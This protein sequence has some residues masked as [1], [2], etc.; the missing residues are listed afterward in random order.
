MAALLGLSLLALFGFV[1]FVFSIGTATV[2]VNVDAAVYDKQTRAPVSNCLLAFEKS[3]TSGYG[4]TSARTD[5][6]GRSS[7]QTSH[8]YVGSMLWPFSRDRNPKLRFYVGEPSGSGAS[9]GV[10]AWDVQLHFREPWTSRAV[11]PRVA[12]RRSGAAP[13]PAAD[14]PRLAEAV[15]HFESNDRGGDQYRIPLS[16]FLDPE[17]SAA[18]RAEPPAEAERRANTLFNARK[19][20]EALTEYRE[21]AQ[22]RPE[23]AWAHQGIGDC[24]SHLDRGKEAIASY[25]TA[26]G[27]APADADIQFDYG[28]SLRDG[29]HE[30]A[31]A[32]F[33]RVTA[34]EPDK[35]RGFIGLGAS[36]YA[37]DRCREAVVAYGKAVELCTSCL[38]D[39]D[40]REYAECRQELGR[41]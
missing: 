37:L 27:L 20:Q 9:P 10:E 38:D 4:Q 25:R 11:V 34:M 40:R 28:N 23:A 30:E 24:L 22:R 32:Q 13:L 5:A 8:S 29:R 21:A 1:V 41:R 15:V 36:L 2:T 12:V 39:G 3:E 18:C 35:A 16:I 14:S 7:H 17:Q 31:V 6:R 26:A 19:Y 33:K